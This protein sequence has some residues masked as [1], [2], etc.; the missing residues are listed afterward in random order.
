MELT[1]RLKITL[2]GL[3]LQRNVTL[4]PSSSAAVTLR[5]GRRSVQPCAVMLISIVAFTA[6]SIDQPNPIVAATPI[7]RLT[8]TS[9]PTH[10]PTPTNTRT[11]TS[12]PTPTATPEPWVTPD[13]RYYFP[14]QPPKIASYAN[15]H[16]D[17]PAA[18]I[19]TPIGSTV[20]AVTDGVID[21]VSRVDRWERKT[22]DGAYRGGL[23]VTIIG[24]DGVRY[25]ASHLSMVIAGLE[26]GGRAHAG[27]I[28][29]YS[30]HTGNATLTPPHVHFGISRPT[31]P[32][33]WIVRRGQVWPYT[34]L[35]AWTRGED[36]TPKVP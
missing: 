7:A 21:E 3:I 14:V 19:F 20:V 8:A 25:H 4:K 9:R 15:E 12:T 33:D 10:T 29:G 16:H 27:Q 36:V 28:I 1:T 32:G 35:K 6:C 2:A 30:G 31:F 24:D 13:R 18:D 5:R 11:P 17:Y 23:W 26:A 34:Y 22:N